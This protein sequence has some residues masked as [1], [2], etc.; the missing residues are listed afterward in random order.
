MKRIAYLEQLSPWGKLL[1][2]F[3]IILILALVSAFLGLLVGKVFFGLDIT[4]IPEIISKPETDHQVLFIKLYQFINQIGVFIVPVFIFSFLVSQNT[5]TYLHIDKK[6]N[7]VNLFVLG[8]VV[9]T[10]LPFLNFLGELNQSMALPEMFSGIENWMLDKEIQAKQLTET[11][12]KT[13]TIGGLSLNLLIV[14]L[15]PAIGEELLFRGLLLKLFKSITRNV[16][17]AVIISS[18]LFAAIHL[19]FY[20]F[21]PRFFLGM[22]LGYSFVIT[23]NLWMPIFIH[24]VNNAASVFVFFLHYN[25]YLN[26]PMEDFGAVQ[27]PVYIIGSLLITI[28]LMVIVYRREGHVVNSLQ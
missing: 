5:L 7:T 13:N 1:L 2:L 15:L 22:V 8:V 28:W 27:S 25:G 4:V 23:Q 9:F 24:L 16:H 6:P 12:L 18:L 3:V 21:L 14:A 26:V 19:Q 17:W 11:F 20:G 10:G